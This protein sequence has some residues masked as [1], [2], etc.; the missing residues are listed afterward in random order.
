MKGIDE[1][2]FLD[3]KNAL[4][5]V[6]QLARLDKERESNQWLDRLLSDVEQQNGYS[7]KVPLLNQAA[8]LSMAYSTLVWLRDLSYGLEMTCCIQTE[9]A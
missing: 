5:L 6:R 2:A 3:A 7:S 1:G 8:F 4:L 9:E